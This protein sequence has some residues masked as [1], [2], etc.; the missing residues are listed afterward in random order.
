LEKR[1]Y[2][3]IVCE[4]QKTEP[5]YFEGL[6][7]TL[8]QGVL[9]TCQINI[10]GLGNNTISLVRQAKNIKSRIEEESG[11]EVDK[12]WVVFD[13]DS[14]SADSFNNAINSCQTSR[15]KIHCA[16][17]NEAFELWY[18]LHFHNFNTALSREDYTG[19][20]EK[21]LKPHLGA[22]FKYK[23]N[24][25]EMFHFLTRYGDIH[26]AIKWAKEL[27]RQYEGQGNFADHNPCTMVF[28]LV[29]E[30]ISMSNPGL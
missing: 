9:T 14:F 6:K 21:N 8:P 1:I 18:L 25:V 26:Q 7:Q 30:L 16:W 15:P 10:Q 2:Y 28:Q 5:N 19:L 20:I 13:K 3:L 22:D 17:S 12:L 24:S 27:A 29:E 23:K 4:G 11:R